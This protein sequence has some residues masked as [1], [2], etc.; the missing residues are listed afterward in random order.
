MRSVCPCLWVVC[1]L[2]VC[3]YLY[4][5]CV[6]LCCLC[7]CV[8]CVCLS[9]SVFCVVCLYC[10]C[11]CVVVTA[12][13]PECSGRRAGMAVGWS[14]GSWWADGAQ[15]WA[16]RVLRRPIRGG[17]AGMT[18]EGGK[19][20]SF[21]SGCCISTLWPGQAQDSFP[22]LPI[23]SQDDPRLPPGSGLQPLSQHFVQGKVPKGLGR[24]RLGQ[25]LTWEAAWHPLLSLDGEE[26]TST[27]PAPTSF[28]FISCP[29]NGHAT[30][31]TSGCGHSRVAPFT[32][33]PPPDH[34]LTSQKMQI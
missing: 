8:V 18:R 16:G 23:C 30:P 12:Q 13:R 29:L 11:V 9:V 26:G 20:L 22:R 14:G 2:S 33:T 25:S 24:H 17:G 10:V 3:V 4:L 27:I 31:P 21:Q 6:C 28:P 15:L 1:L 34:R 7:V 5:L 19:P 32:H